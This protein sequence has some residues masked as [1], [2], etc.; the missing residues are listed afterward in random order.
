MN[1][2]LPRNSSSVRWIQ[3]AAVALVTTNAQSRA[4]STDDALAAAIIGNQIGGQ[5]RGAITAAGEMRSSAGRASSEIGEARR[6]YWAAVKS[7]RGVAAARQQFAEQ[8]RAK[9]LYYLMMAIPEGTEGP[10]ARVLALLTGNIDGGIRPSARPQFER[11]VTQIRVELGAQG[12]LERGSGTQRMV[13][14]G[15]AELAKALAATEEQQAFYVRARDWAEVDASG[16]RF[17]WDTDSKASVMMLLHR[18]GPLHTAAQV[19]EIYSEL[20]AMFGENAVLAAADVVRKARRTPSGDVANALSLGVN[21]SAPDA[22]FAELL[23]T[24]NGES[25]FKYILWQGSE[26]VADARATYN[27]W[28]LAHGEQAVRDAATSVMRRRGDD[29]YKYI[30]LPVLYRD[31]M[32]RLDRRGV[33]PF[34]R[35]VI[36]QGERVDSPAEL[37]AAYRRLADRH[38]EAK[39]RDAAARLRWA[40]RGGSFGSRNSAERSRRQ[41]ERGKHAGRRADYAQLL[42]ILERGPS[43]ELAAYPIDRC[44]FSEHA[45]ARREGL[46]IPRVP[47]GEDALLARLEYPPEDRAAGRQGH[48][49]VAAVVDKT[50]DAV[51][52]QVF[53]T[54]KATPT[55]VGAAMELVRSAPWAPASENGTPLCMGVVLDV[56]FRLTAAEMATA[57]RAAPHAVAPADAGYK[58]IYRFGA[59]GERL[60]FARFAGGAAG[61]MFLH[62][63]GTVYGIGVDGGFFSRLHEIDRELWGQGP[64]QI[65]LLAG[66]DGNLYGSVKTPNPKITPAGRNRSQVEPRHPFGVLFRIDSEGSFEVIHDF[67]RAEGT[68]PRLLHVGKD[69]TLYGVVGGGKVALF[70]TA[71]DGSGFQRLH[72]FEPEDRNWMRML[73]NFYLTDDGEG[74]LFGVL[75]SGVGDSRK[76][77]IFRL[78]SS[79]GGYVKLGELER[80]MFD[81]DPQILVGNDGRIYGTVAVLLGR[82][83]YASLVFAMDG[84]GENFS[85]LHRHEGKQLRNLVEGPGGMLYGTS[86]SA[87]RGGRDD[88]LFRIATDG[89][90]F[91]LL[92]VKDIGRIDDVL[93]QGGAIFVVSEKGISRYVPPP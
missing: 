51:L 56:P 3:L 76:G 81:G 60:S 7:G 86:A 74:T 26:S 22:V 73:E 42:E 88:R 30:G 25:F 75:M 32:E 85:E 69:G 77:E 20:A 18:Y 2:V 39:L 36:A 5:V 61:R 19:K 8:L 17:P 53:D 54:S 64:S 16:L 84:D 65:A 82:Q 72:E 87:G 55:M 14:P 44:E 28:V 11:W 38:G 35:G 67:T 52:V 31:I 70:R 23:A 68:W 12:S 63:N 13:I 58:E 6:R 1:D 93:A 79:G 24:R 59:A 15:A 41:E 43:P 50:G 4:Q 80:V 9:D 78:S 89:S 10:R 83:N 40:W 47:G 66:P 45:F 90:R 27:R 92:D 21:A 57:S 48:V 34:L 71:S 33:E 49:Q 91:E 29:R 46:Q 37:N 62:D